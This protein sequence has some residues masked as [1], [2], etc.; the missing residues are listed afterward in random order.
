M[1]LS[2]NQLSSHFIKMVSKKAR[3]SETERFIELWHEEESVWSI[4]SDNYDIT[5]EKEKS[6]RR[7]S[8]KLEMTNNHFFKMFT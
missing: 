8:E 1:Y 6:V 2:I 4:L 5:Q 3:L 7:V